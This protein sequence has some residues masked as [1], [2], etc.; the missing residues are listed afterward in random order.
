MHT[1]SCWGRSWS[2]TCIAL[3]PEHLCSSFP[4]MLLRLQ[5]VWDMRWSEDDPDLFAMMEKTKMYIFR[6]AVQGGLLLPDAACL[7]AVLLG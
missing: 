7:H 1:A 6:R 5:D 4:G 2:R 3:S